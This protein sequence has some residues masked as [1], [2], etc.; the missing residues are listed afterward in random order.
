MKIC[1]TSQGTSLNSLVDPRFGRC[2]HFIFIENGAKEFY[3]VP[4]PG[5]SMIR[6]AGISAAQTV[7][8]EGAEVVITGNMGPNAFLVL[9]QSGVKV[10][11]VPQ[12]VSCAKALEMF[13]KGELKEAKAP[14]RGGFGWGFGGGFRG[15]FGWGWR[16]RNDM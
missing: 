4:N 6:G 2:S 9:N 7:I 11:F 15:R 5:V 3:S 13:Q 8:N 10:Y 12:I 1:I 14:R 16:W